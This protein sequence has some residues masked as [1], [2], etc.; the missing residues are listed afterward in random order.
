MDT[1]K[2][3]NPIKEVLEGLFTLLESTETQSAAVLEFLKDQGVATDEKLAPYL[4]RAASASS[5]K[6]RAARARMAYLLAPAPKKATK[7]KEAPDA[8]EP[9]GKAVEQKDTQP[10]GAE[11]KSAEPEVT[12]LRES[13][14]KGSERESNETKELDTKA[15]PKNAA[16]RETKQKGASEKS[17]EPGSNSTAA[18]V[19][20][21][22]AVSQ[23][24]SPDLKHVDDSKQVA[25]SKAAAARQSENDQSHNP[26]TPASS[27]QSAK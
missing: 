8:K 20:S 3:D 18:S 27:T 12:A 5:V 11:A 4:D 7:Q 17:G 26:A 1:D 2:T 16:P 6:W 21:T 13:D 24:N 25:K 22:K 19:K 23:N 10:N 9:Q 15:E 14:P